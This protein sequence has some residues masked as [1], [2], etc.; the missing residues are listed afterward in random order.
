MGKGRRPLP[1][2]IK[3]L[4]GNPGRRPIAE[5]PA[6]E[7][8]KKQY[9]PRGLSDIGRREWR[10]MRDELGRLGLLATCNPVTLEV[11]ARTYQ[12]WREAEDHLA[13]DRDAAGRVI[14]C[15]IRTSN[16]QIRENP[17]LAIA[18]KAQRQLIKILG[19]L[20]MTPASRQHV[21]A[22][23]GSKDDPLKEFL[24]SAESRTG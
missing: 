23:S 5:P 8:P 9:C 22:A 19:E 17:W 14:G 11:Y 6:G 21:G 10:R 15:L 12:R 3:R 1:A 2:A 24:D 4:K 20:G 18:D 13:N 16:G 7:W